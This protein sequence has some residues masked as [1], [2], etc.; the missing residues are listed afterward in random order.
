MKRLIVPIVVLIIVAVVWIV[1]SKREKARISG[2]VTEN[3]LELNCES[4]NRIVASSPAR[5][6]ELIKTDGLWYIKDSIPR[7]AE[8]RAVTQ[9]LGRA[10]TLSV[11]EVFSQNVDKQ[12]EFNV[13]DDRGTTISFYDGDSLV[14]AIVVGKL[15]ADMTRTYL[16]KKESN[17][18]YIVPPV[19]NFAFNM[20]PGQWMDKNLI[21]CNQDS[22]S[23]VEI[24]YPSKAYRLEP[25][26]DTGGQ[27]R[28]W[29]IVNLKGGQS[30]GVDARGSVVFSFLQQACALRAFDMVGQQD[31]GKVDFDPVSLSII[32]NRYDE[33]AD[34]VQ[35]AQVPPGDTPRRFYARRPAGIDTFVVANMTYEVLAKE[36]DDFAWPK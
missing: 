27:V 33:T 9:I 32:V 30:K 25:K 20:T 23:S 26:P 2:T 5:E 31:I 17:D 21:V 4:I 34:T 8:Q 16:R 11:G 7:L 28:E 29:T 24:I 6:V 22:V 1:V 35:F 12:D 36:Y 15:N 13:T 19:F 10:C 18:V 3:F 14:S